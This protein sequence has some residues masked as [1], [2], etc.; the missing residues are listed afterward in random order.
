MATCCY[1]LCYL[2]VFTLIGI[3]IGNENCTLSILSVDMRNINCSVHENIPSDTL[4]LDASSFLA[5]TE[6]TFYELITDGDVVDAFNQHFSYPTQRSNVF[7]L[8]S[9]GDFDREQMFGA[10][11][12]P[13]KTG[14]ML[15]WSGA[16]LVENANTNVLVFYTLNI[17]VMDENDNAPVFDED[18][19]TRTVV[20]VLDSSIP[21]S[22]ILRYL[23]EAVDNDEQHNAIQNYTLSDTYDGLFRLVVRLEGSSNIIRL[24][25]TQGLD[26]ETRDNY[27]FQVEA[28]DGGN[29]AGVLNVLL[30]VEDINDN[31]PT[32]PQTR[33]SAMIQESSDTQP[34]ID[35][36][37]TDAD[38]GSN[39]EITYTLTVSS[40]IRTITGFFI[41]NT[42]T[43]EIRT[44]GLI[45]R[46][47]ASQYHMTVRIT[48]GG[49]PANQITVTVDVS[50]ADI[51]DNAPKVSVNLNELTEGKVREDFEVGRIIGAVTVS[52]P[53]EGDNARITDPVLVDLDMPDEPPTTFTLQARDQAD[54]WDLVLSQPL[55]R[56][57]R[58]NYN[59]VIM[60]SDHGMPVLTT[61]ES[62]S[63]G[64]FDIN[65]NRPIFNTSNSYRVTVPENIPVNDF[66]IGVHASDLDSGSNGAITYSLADP[67]L[68]F[69]YQEYFNI[70]P[71]LGD[72]T[73]AR[74]LDREEIDQLYIEVIAT[75]TGV[76]PRSSQRSVLVILTDVNDNRPIFA[77]DTSA[78]ITIRENLDAQL[79]Y[80]FSAVDPDLPPFANVTY[81]LVNTQGGP[82]MIDTDSGSLF[83]TDSLDREVNSDYQLRIGASDDD[84]FD[85]R[86]FNFSVLVDDV[87]DVA[88]S[89]A[90]A[91]HFETVPENATI[92]T[93]IATLVVNDPDLNNGLQFTIVSGNSER[94][95]AVRTSG[96]SGIVVVVSSLDRETTDS[97]TLVVSV[98]DSAPNVAT[99][100]TSVE[101]TVSD[102]N[103]HPP[104]FDRLS[105]TFTVTENS[106]MTNVGR[107]FAISNDTGVY[108]R[109]IYRITG[110]NSENFFTI[111]QQNG[112]ISTLRSV[113]REMNEMF[114]LIIT[115]EDGGTPPLYNE[116]RVTINVGDLN[117]NQPMFNPSHVNISLREDFSL[118]QTFYTASANDDDI[119]ENAVSRYSVVSTDYNGFRINVSTGELSLTNML[120][121]N[122]ASSIQVVIE[123]RDSGRSDFTARLYL[124]ISVIDIDDRLP[125]FPPDFPTSTVVNETVLGG[126]V[127]LRFQ[128]VII[129]PS[130]ASHFGY[131]LS[132][133]QGDFELR[134]Q[135][136][137]ASI[138]VVGL[139]RENIDRYTLNITITNLV[140]D[141]ANL[142]NSKLLEV[143]V[144]DSNDNYPSFTETHYR[145][146]VPENLD[147]HIFNPVEATD[148]D[149]GSNAMIRYTLRD[150]SDYF[151]I[152]PMDGVIRTVMPLDHDAAPTHS[153][154][155]VASDMGNPP[156][157]TTAGVTIS[158]IDLN[159]NFPVF[160]PDQLYRFEIEEDADVGAL[161]GR[162][163]ATDNDSGQF[164]TIFYSIEGGNPGNKFAINQDGEITVSNSL[165]RETI[166]LYSLMIG[167]ADNGSPPNSVLQVFNVTVLDVNDEAPIFDSSQNRVV[168][169][170]ENV[171][172]GHLVATVSASDGD[173]GTNSIVSYMLGSGNYN[174]AFSIDPSLG[175]IRTESRLDH[176]VIFYYPL[177][178]IALDMGSPSR[179]SLQLFNITVT[180]VNNHNPV[181]DLTRYE[182]TVRE[183]ASLSTILLRVHAEDDDSGN[184]GE[185]TYEI[186]VQSPTR[187]F[188][189]DDNGNI[190]PLRTLNYEHQ[191]EYLLD[192]AAVD[193]DRISTNKRT[194]TTQVH[195]VIQNIN[196]NDP[197]FLNLPHTV[198]LSELV[199]LDSVAYVASAVDPDSD[200][201]QYSIT[202]GNNDNKFMMNSQT[203]EVFISSQLDRD[204]T[205]S[206]SLTVTVTDGTNAVSSQLNIVVEDVNDNSPVFSM[207][208]YMLDV[209][210]LSIPGSVVGTITATDDDEGVNA[211][212][213][214]TL[215]EPSDYFSINRSTGELMLLVSIDRENPLST[216]I[217][218]FQ[219][220]ATDMGIIFRNS[221]TTD[222][223]IQI[224]DEND[225]PP[226]FTQN[227]FRFVIPRSF[228]VGA[229]FGRINATDADERTNAEHSFRITESSNGF[230]LFKVNETTGDLS[231][232]SSLT[233][234]SRQ[235][236]TLTVRAT[237]LLRHEFYNDT[238]VEVVVTDTNDHPPVFGNDT[239]FITLSEASTTP[240]VIL[241]VEATDEDSGVEFANIRYSFASLHSQFIINESTGAITL[242]DS[243]DYE[244]ITEYS[245]LVHAV[246]PNGRNSSATVR[247]YVTDVNDNV[248][249]FIDLPNT[250]TISE[251][252]YV[253][254]EVLHITAVDLD[255]GR[256]SYSI[257]NGEAMSVFR[258]DNNTG[259]V[260]NLVELTAGS[261]HTLDIAATDSDGTTTPATI[262]LTVTDL[263]SQSPLIDTAGISVMVPENTA[264]NTPIHSLNVT[265]QLASSAPIQYR[266]SNGSGGI[267]S[268]NETTGQL[269]LA[270]S[271]DREQSPA[272]YFILE[273]YQITSGTRYSSYIEVVILV[274]DINDNAPVI[275][276]PWIVRNVS[277]GEDVNFPVVTVMADDDDEGNNA[278]LR[279]TFTAG[280]EGNVFSIGPTNGL[281]VLQERLD[282]ET[283]RAHRLTVTVSDRGSPSLSSTAIVN[284]GV[285]DVNDVAPSFRSAN[286]T[287]RVPEN[288]TQQFVIGVV[289]AIDPDLS[290]TEL[291]YSVTS[292]TAYKND[293]TVTM[294]LTSFRVGDTSGQITLNHNL[295]H[296]TVDMYV[297]RIGVSDGVRSNSTY[298][299]VMIVDCN[300]EAPVFSTTTY[301]K[302]I[303]EL[304]A[305]GMSVIQVTASDGDSGLNGIVRYSLSNAGQFSIDPVTGVISLSSPAPMYRS[306]VR[307]VG[308]VVAT[309]LGNTPQSATATVTI[310]LIDINNHAPQLSPPYVKEIFDDAVVGMTILTVS[311]SDDQDQGANSDVSYYISGIQGPVM[312]P[313]E[314]DRTTGVISVSNKVVP[315]V[316]TFTVT[317]INEN[318]DPFAAQYVLSSSATVQITVYQV[319][320]N[321][322]QFDRT[323]YTTE[324][325][326]L[327]DVNYVA[328]HVNATDGDEGSVV[329]YSLKSSVSLP[330]TI[331]STGAISLTNTLDRETID[332]YNFEVVATDDGRPRKN[333]TVSVTIRV[334]DENDNDP[335]FSANIIDASVK[336]NEAPN[337]LVRAI[338]AVDAD[339]V[340]NTRL[341]YSINNT[342]VF[343][344]D[345]DSG[346]ITTNEEIDREEVAEFYLQIVANDNGNPTSRSSSAIVRVTVLGV[347][348]YRPAFN[349][350]SPRNFNVSTKA[351]RGSIVGQ[352]LAYDQDKGKEGELI[353]TFV[354]FDDRYDPNDFFYINSSG[355]IILN[356]TSRGSQGN[357]N[358]RKRQAEDSETEDLIPIATGVEV[359]D[360]GSDPVTAHTRIT[361]VIPESFATRPT[362]SGSDPSDFPL[363]PIVAAVVCAV[364]VFVVI[365]IVLCVCYRCRRR[366]RNKL[367]SPTIT[368]TETAARPPG[369][370]RVSVVSFTPTNVNG[371]AQLDSRTEAT[372]TRLEVVA[373]ETSAPHAHVS[374]TSDSEPASG[375]FGDDESESVSRMR[376]NNAEHVSPSGR[377]RSP[378]HSR[379][380][381]ISRST[382][383]LNAAVNGQIP[384]ASNGFLRRQDDE[385]AHP[386][387]RDQ[388]IAIYAANANLLTN[389]PSQDSIHMFGSE[390][391][392]EA[393][394]DI[395]MDNYMFAKFAGGLDSADEESVVGMNNDAYTVSSRGRSSIA[396]RSSGGGI[397]EGPEDLWRGSR[398]SGFRTHLVTDVIDELQHTASLSKE[399]LSQPKEKR[400]SKPATH[401]MQ[402]RETSF[403]TKKPTGNSYTRHTG[404]M[405]NVRYPD[406]VGNSQYEYDG[407]RSSKSQYASSGALCP[408]SYSSRASEL[409]LPPYRPG[410]APPPYGNELSPPMRPVQPPEPDSPSSDSDSSEYPPTTSNVPT[411]APQPVSPQP[412]LPTTNSSI[413]LD[414]PEFHRQPLFTKPYSNKLIANGAVSRAHTGSMPQVY[415][416]SIHGN[417]IGQGMD[418]PRYVNGNLRL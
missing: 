292:L 120:D 366:G 56:E 161:V 368:V 174:D 231:L 91:T 170:G 136:G 235:S 246:N 204:V 362:T 90:D 75:D 82:F 399:N 276:N 240:Q 322:P 385:E 404:S 272:Y 214:Y 16:L 238:M 154:V 42:T 338:T 114:Q 216:L 206:Y 298:V 123:A 71:T 352:L 380:P 6:T 253:N 169:I 68:E 275:R 79:I 294:P 382:S 134:T 24:E 290:P 2:T 183:D 354:E 210:E 300:D 278:D 241:T 236:Y 54:I 19:I 103:D 163:V 44:T 329:S 312:I 46:E 395:D 256:V 69:Q 277:E 375:I 209:P 29:Q 212:I 387:T 274:G 181:F 119:G 340:V 55:D 131:S 374:T 74:S 398:T 343:T 3:V 164:G 355:F 155:V 196:D 70:H 78:Q 77:A 33:Y 195:V 84:A 215:V 299:T 18:T 106:P 347:N 133:H 407:R 367:Y 62:L 182:V 147:E 400:K 337:T 339:S 232:K 401:M 242:T 207:D 286:Y 257:T 107:V 315:D 150:P 323:S 259:V 258:I 217:I 320:L 153:L 125:R 73:V 234:E 192:V 222:V 187:D 392:G 213:E 379:P 94:K 288:A 377:H 198:R 64:V 179:K 270:N 211:Q 177:E 389:S 281:I 127:L 190:R 251:V 372:T 202:G 279:Y 403:T 353:F 249:Q 357:S 116:T 314:I 359:R 132:G 384:H 5:I 47:N 160:S 188:R 309:D 139:N 115:A 199:S 218:T 364:V 100:T 267:F 17:H 396:S 319:N 110:G 122:A 102:I 297:I 7:V 113:D 239:Y 129:A 166:S 93:I 317:A 254:L 226:V 41:I 124:N 313:F 302:R 219:V 151:I 142:T 104:Q 65:D 363:I 201:L 105:Y 26:R 156:K 311:A 349:S 23:P 310:S 221:R 88:P 383:D 59:L 265:S 261:T 25:S 66:V 348:E 361:I 45:D 200:T 266:I 37:A 262:V 303:P 52:D 87:N 263:S 370:E 49:S 237:D 333:S 58:E 344:I 85:P 280:N 121:Y 135:N 128:A 34:V 289:S 157:S 332:I 405:Q 143:I 308:T 273:A 409:T 417:S 304:S 225:N 149:D 334:L 227:L 144:S 173:T 11:S 111:N 321:P 117:D 193:G 268:I 365:L 126:H 410:E 89:F 394:G 416:G 391:G 118:M 140:A 152:S 406:H 408:L 180:N 165:D 360:N 138:V 72:V 20:E 284:I 411:Y 175:E 43:G 145:F 97:Y 336:E 159:D 243:L 350:T 86:Y 287:F 15:V 22:P 285:L 393:D 189:I 386:Y 203:G 264:V 250:L 418:R 112:S 27:T 63:I 356:A 295:D 40:G 255:S 186:L 412:S 28:R 39:G 390:G 108:G 342:Q 48:D 81:S 162:V 305:T 98:M 306:N 80:N 60:V 414:H 381:P 83:T 92:D 50:V 21:S 373:E 99:N 32:V 51:N 345:Q 230:L 4:I 252:P 413:S 146:E 224:T 191:P 271:L 168:L 148:D 378:Q 53:D 248:P 233:T 167:V 31:S 8:R 109:V 67:S 358:R 13:S 282:R 283:M 351:S 14:S 141:I 9:R 369:S 397:D 330:F 158:V 318:P 12:D 197:S 402:F 130:E 301:T 171:T 184:L 335:Q 205:S 376:V 1:L 35:I 326:E 223:T 307:L 328:L 61:N 415:P 260:T 185:V 178:V 324:V 57:R 341:T 228:S 38:S 96:S 30:I 245:L 388:L 371:T 244:S 331:S 36:N 325:S 176:E 220:T 247:I 172:P 346:R 194:G 10:L 95:F 327:E 137:D 296:E 76:D 269:L 316:V 291:R 293:M 208:P 101:I 229:P